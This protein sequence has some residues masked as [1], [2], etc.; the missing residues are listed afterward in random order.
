M[1]SA[2]AVYDAGE[3]NLALI[4]LVSVAEELLRDVASQQRIGTR[5]QDARSIIRALEFDGVIDEATTSVPE[6]A[7]ERRNEL[8]HGGMATV[9]PSGRRCEDCRCVSGGVGGEAVAGGVIRCAVL[10]TEGRANPEHVDHLA[11]VRF[12]TNYKN[13]VW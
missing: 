9:S 6:R 2:L 7:W 1:L 12:S 4:S 5:D 10:V 11:L 13:G 3:R 8:V